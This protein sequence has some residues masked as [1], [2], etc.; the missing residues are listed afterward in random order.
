MM[1]DNHVYNLLEQLVTEQKSLWRMKDAY[2]KDTGGCSD[3]NAMWEEMAKDKEKHIEQL[4]NLVKKHW[5]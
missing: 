5:K 1:H 3:C 4:T 2:Q